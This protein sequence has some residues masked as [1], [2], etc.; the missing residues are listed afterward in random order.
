MSAGV[1]EALKLVGIV[2]A[3]AA[4]GIALTACAPTLV[5]M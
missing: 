5:L 2:A 3:V 1:R 4:F